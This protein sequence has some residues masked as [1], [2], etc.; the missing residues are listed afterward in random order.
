MMSMDS[1]DV[2]DFLPNTRGQY[3]LT[4]DP[5]D[6]LTSDSIYFR[7]PNVT[8][9]TAAAALDHV[10]EPF[11][12]RYGPLATVAIVSIAALLTVATSGG[13]LL[14]ITAFRVDSQLQR[15]S[16]YFLLSLAVADFAIGAVSMP[17][18]TV[19]LLLG[20]WPLGKLRHIFTTADV[21]LLII[22]CACNFILFFSKI[23]EKR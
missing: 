7:Y 6:R 20:R 4:S 9:L 12:L 18:F 2:S 23:A 17:L 8:E 13:N 10:Y 14:V 22:A 16:N 1:N 21:V 3:F 15:V 19:Y 5:F 11:R